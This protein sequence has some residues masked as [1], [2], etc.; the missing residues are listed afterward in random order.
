ML[1]LIMPT[2]V[3]GAAWL[4]V[5]GLRRD[6]DGRPFLAIFA[7]CYVGIGISFYPYIVPPTLTIAGAAAPDEG[8]AFLLVGAAVLIPM[9]LAYIGYAYWVFRGKVRPGDGYHG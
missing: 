1:S 2:L 5:D 7:L 4:L 9:I 6:A 3:A 8:L